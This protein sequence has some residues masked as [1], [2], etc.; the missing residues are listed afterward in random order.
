MGE[1][2]WIRKEAKVTGNRFKKKHTQ[3]NNK[4]KKNFADLNRGT[5][6]EGMIGEDCELGGGEMGWYV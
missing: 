2:R 4:R 3:N 6:N 5:W 1:G